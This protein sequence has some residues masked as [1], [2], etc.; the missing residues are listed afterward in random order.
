V[1]IIFGPGSLRKTDGVGRRFAPSIKPR[2]FS[3][4]REFS[5]FCLDSESPVG[6]NINMRKLWFGGSFNPIH[7]GHLI[8]ARA[9]AESA[10]FDQITLIPSGQSPHKSAEYAMADANHRLEMCRLA[11]AGDDFFAVDDIEV[12][13]SGPSFTVNTVTEL[14][15]RGETEVAWLIGADMALFLPSWHQP[16]RLLAETSFFLMARPGWNLDWS[17]MPPEFRHLQKNVVS[18][19]ELEISSTAIRNRWAAGKSI[20]YL[21]PDAVIQYINAKS[22]YSKKHIS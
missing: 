10:G 13:R 12:R 22:L 7:V 3:C 16:A 4:Q 15:A 8:C 20:R 18:A 6:S 11:V 14:K 19:P 1:K 5:A 21:T 2:H 9:V 17:Q